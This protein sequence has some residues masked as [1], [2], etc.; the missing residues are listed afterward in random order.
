MLAWSET[1]SNAVWSAAPQLALTGGI[2]DPKGGT[3]AWQLSNNSAGDQSVTQV[4]NVPATYTYTFSVY[5]RASQAT[6]VTLLLGSATATVTLANA[7]KRYQITGSGNAT[8]T[9]VT[10]GIKCRRERS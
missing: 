3:N 8:E 10:V 1:L 4:L 9:Y 6:S 7:W 5:L 2:Q